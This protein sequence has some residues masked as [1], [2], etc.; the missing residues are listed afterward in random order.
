MAYDRHALHGA[1]QLLHEH[2]NRLRPG[3][4]VR[5]KEI[6]C[7][8]FPTHDYPE[9]TYSRLKKKVANPESLDLMLEWQTVE[10]VL[11]GFKDLID[12]L[13]AKNAGKTSRAI[14]VASPWQAIS[15]DVIRKLDLDLGKGS[16]LSHL[17]FKDV[18]PRSTAALQVHD[19]TL[20]KLKIRTMFDKLTR[21]DPERALSKALADLG[22]KLIHQ[23]PDSLPF[24]G[25]EVL[26][27]STVYD[28]RDWRP[29]AMQEQI[30]MFPVEPCYSTRV[31]KLRLPSKKAVSV[32]LEFDTSGYGVFPV[33]AKDNLG[34][35][36][37]L[38][39]LH[40]KKMPESAAPP[41]V[42][43]A[44]FSYE[45]HDAVREVR[46]IVRSIFFNGLQQTRFNPDAAETDPASR[47]W[48]SKR[49]DA[50]RQGVDMAVILPRNKKIDVGRFVQRDDS[51]QYLDVPGDQV[52]E[53]FKAA[54][55]RPG[56]GAKDT[57]VA[58]W[59]APRVDG[60]MVVSFRWKWEKERHR[61]A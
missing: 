4:P 60:P 54:D 23:E 24:G 16:E 27:D 52:S 53:I 28:C 31:V 2:A 55:Q 40:T 42:T 41:R 34:Q 8:A 19:N 58:I 43:F 21:D 13:H 57:P 35:K 17:H 48:Y 18:I 26:G 44:E 7:R 38:S 1:I 6:A 56:D 5:D 25:C 49:T 30:R 50:G 32:R 36:A 29:V 12:E 45:P 14:A 10:C 39:F 15:E 46:L 61:S 3:D 20:A 9:A 22:I 37:R 59:H 11:N 51:G 47:E 33:E